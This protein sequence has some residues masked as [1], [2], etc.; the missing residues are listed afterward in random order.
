MNEHYPSEEAYV[1]ALAEA[2]KTEYDTI[3]GAGLLLQVD[4]AFIP[5]NY[6]R[7]VA[8]G[9]VDAGR[10]GSTASCASRR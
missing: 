9:H 3:V 6:D 7:L 1:Y 4:D 2:L 5:Y 8:P 10:T